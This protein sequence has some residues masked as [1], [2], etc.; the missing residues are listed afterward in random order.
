MEIKFRPFIYANGKKVF[1]IPVSMCK[2][3]DVRNRKE[4]DKIKKVGE[5]RVEYE[6]IEYIP[7]RIAQYEVLEKP[8]PVH[9]NIIR[10][11]A[12]KLINVIR[13]VR[14]LMIVSCDEDDTTYIELTLLDDFK[15][16]KIR[17]TNILT[18]RDVSCYK[19]RNV[20]LEMIIEYYDKFYNEDDYESVFGLK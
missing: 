12:S 10:N 3:I 4:Y 20:I 5:K 16:P 14:P 17:V 1:Y 18:T 11:Y 19:S 15:S 2:V 13:S 8:I 7:S 6:G 9:F